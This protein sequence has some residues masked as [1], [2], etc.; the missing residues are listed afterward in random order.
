MRNILLRSE[1][2]CHGWTPQQLADFAGISLST[3]ERA[4]KGGSIRVDCIQRRCECL[5]KMPVDLGLLRMDVRTPE[6][7]DNLKQRPAFGAFEE[8]DGCF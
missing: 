2:L 8:R 3:V 4:E 5:S 6:S 7:G 1:R